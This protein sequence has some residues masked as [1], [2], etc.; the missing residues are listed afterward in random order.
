MKR[1]ILI[2]ALTIIVMSSFAQQSIRS[3]INSNDSI[4]YLKI[5]SLKAEIFILKAELQQKEMIN[6]VRIAEAK[7]YR[8]Y[9]KSIMKQK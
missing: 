5:D 8:K 9:R 1:T 4:L 7:S 3:N 2:A 6:I